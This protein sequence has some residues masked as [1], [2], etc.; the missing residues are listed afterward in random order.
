M[1]AWTKDQLDAIDQADEL[2][3]I[4]LRCDGSHRRP[5]PVWVVRV[6][7][8]GDVVIRSYHGSGGSW[9]RHARVDGSGRVRI[10]V[11]GMDQAVTF[12]PMTDRDASETINDAYRTKYGRYRDSYLKPMVAEASQAA[13]LRLTPQDN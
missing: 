12:E 2:E 4:T 11:A 7:G 3:V 6:D 13:T 1:S 9:Y 10:R 8:D 5:V